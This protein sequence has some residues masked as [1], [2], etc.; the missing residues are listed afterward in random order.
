[1]GIS[2]H[3]GSAGQTG[4]GS[5]TGESERWLKEALEVD[6]LSLPVGTL[7]REPGGRAP[8]V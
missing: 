5:S 3:G 8:L 7:L 2:L 4:V 1:M 6:C